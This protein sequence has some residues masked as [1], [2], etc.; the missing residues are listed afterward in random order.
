MRTLLLAILLAAC[1]SGS[2]H[3]PSMASKSAAARQDPGRMICHEE[4]PTGTN[5]SREVCRT[6]E[7]IEAE[8][9]GAD[10]LLHTQNA[11][12]GVEF[13]GLP[14]PSGQGK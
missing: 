5:I 13:N 10:D 12:F 14:A 2:G 7:E 11:R 4:T 9:K 8:R 6:P 1:A 3:D